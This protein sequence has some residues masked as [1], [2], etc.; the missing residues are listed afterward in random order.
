MAFVTVNDRSD[1]VAPT[2]APNNAAK[3]KK[4]GLLARAFAALVEARRHA[5]EREIREYLSGRGQFLTDN[6][7]REIDRILS[8]RGGF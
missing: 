5:A 7:E 1:F 8:S 3:T 6:A 4:P 2:A